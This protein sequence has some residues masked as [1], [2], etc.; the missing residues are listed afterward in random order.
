MSYLQYTMYSRI[1]HGDSPA[2]GGET[3]R[4]SRQGISHENRP[5]RRTR[6]VSWVCTLTFCF[7][8]HFW[9]QQTIVLVINQS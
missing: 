1:L 7:S 8:L 6:H 2:A 5:E 4:E 3:E 9:D